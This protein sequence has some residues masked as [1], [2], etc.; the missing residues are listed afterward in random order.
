M[1]HTGLCQGQIKVDLWIF[2]EKPNTQKR[3]NRIFE[4]KN[5]KSEDKSIR[6]SSNPTE[7]TS[8]RHKQQEVMRQRRRNS[9]F[10][11]IVFF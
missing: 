5:Q 7:L 10:L 3:E 1:S 4:R 9:L 2:G 11:E 8:G 6:R